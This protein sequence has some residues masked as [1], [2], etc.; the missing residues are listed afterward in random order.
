M[1]NAEFGVRNERQTATALTAENA[2]NGDRLGNGKRQTA[3]ALTA[4]DAENAENS[5][6]PGK[7][8]TATAGAVPAQ[9]LGVAMGG[10]GM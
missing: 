10:L 3:T 9:R 7:R 1:R 8:P 5:V 4:K 6:N 2:E